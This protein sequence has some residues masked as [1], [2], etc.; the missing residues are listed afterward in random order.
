[1]EF[2][3]VQMGNGNIFDGKKIGEL[4]EFV[5][6]KFSKEGLSYDEAWIVLEQ[7]KSTI[8][9]FCMVQSLDRK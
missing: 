7:I 5:I 2:S 1:M 3:S 6:D 4:T 8:G 9:E